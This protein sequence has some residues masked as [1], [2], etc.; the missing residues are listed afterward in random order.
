MA[1]I[2]AENKAVVIKGTV[3]SHFQNEVLSWHHINGEDAN[4][5]LPAL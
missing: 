5:L 1:K 2:A 4:D 3:G